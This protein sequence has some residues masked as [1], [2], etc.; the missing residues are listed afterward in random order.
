M[1]ENKPRPG[2][3]L[4]RFEVVMTTKQTYTPGYGVNSE[5]QRKVI[6]LAKSSA[7]AI[8]RCKRRYGIREKDLV[9]LGSYGYTR[10][11]EFTATEITE[12]EA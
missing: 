11:I 8:Q 6:L 5:E 10:R 9:V 3:K 4:K 1:N 7:Q 12:K 2:P